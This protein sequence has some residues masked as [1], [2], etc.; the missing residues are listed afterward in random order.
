MP[1]QFYSTLTIGKSWPSVSG[2]TGG[3]RTPTSTWFAVI[4]CCVC[5][6][7]FNSRKFSLFFASRVERHMCVCAC[8][9]R[10]DQRRSLAQL[11]YEFHAESHVKHTMRVHTHKS[12]TQIRF[13]NQSLC[14][15][16]TI[17]ARRVILSLFGK[18]ACARVLG[19]R[20]VVVCE[21]FSTV[22]G[23]SIDACWNPTNTRHT[24]DDV[25]HFHMVRELN[26]RTSN[27]NADDL[28]N[29]SDSRHLAGVCVF[30]YLYW[31]CWTI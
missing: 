7:S 11:V 18:C 9:R 10:A 22:D 3:A 23:G 17:R 21:H 4:L 5:F 31:F 30:I 26:V 12:F 20:S 27:I 24:C 16:H 15:F 8:N 1:R 28:I 25:I 29:I 2:C 6:C 14:K 13:S 19:W